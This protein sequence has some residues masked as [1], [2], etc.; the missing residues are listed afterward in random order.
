MH[1]PDA[2]TAKRSAPHLGLVLRGVTAGYGSAPVVHDVTVEARPGEVTGLIGPNG[3]GKTTLI[4]VAARGLAPRA[5]TV[6]V[7]GVD[8]YHTSARRAA[9]LVAE[10]LR[11]IELQRRAVQV[12]RIGAGPCRLSLVFE[13]DA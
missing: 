8:P 13:L 3:S 9:R 5:C 10:P 7:G 6:W 11:A 1:E 4:R 12:P 2:V